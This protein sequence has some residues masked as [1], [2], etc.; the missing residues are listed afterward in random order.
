MIDLNEDSN[1]SIKKY[2]INEPAQ[3]LLPLANGKLSLRGILP[4]T[5]IKLLA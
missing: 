2:S 4:P 1:C 3:K 5:N